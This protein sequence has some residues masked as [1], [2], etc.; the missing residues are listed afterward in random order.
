M[1]AKTWSSDE[2]RDPSAADKELP[3]DHAPFD[4]GLLAGS[5]DEYIIT[6]SAFKGQGGF[7]TRDTRS[8]GVGVDLVGRLFS[9]VRIV[10]E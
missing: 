10:S 8:A 6:S 7:F 2:T 3:P 1:L 9:W 5:Q 4:F